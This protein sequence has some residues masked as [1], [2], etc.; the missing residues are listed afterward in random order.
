MKYK[1]ITVETT[2][3]GSDLVSLILIEEGSEGVSVKD[4]KEF[5]SE[6][7]SFSWDYIDEEAFAEEGAF[8]TGVFACDYDES[9]LLSRLDELKAV[10]EFD[11]GSLSVKVLPLMS[12]DYENEWKKYYKVLE[13]GGVA[14]VPE[15]LEYHGSLIPVYIDPG[16]AFGT[17]SHETTSMC[18]KLLQEFDVGGKYVLDVGCG[19]GILGI[20]ALKLGAKR[21]TMSDIDSVCTEATVR[22]CALNGVEKDAEIICGDLTDKANAD[23]LVA[24]ITADILLRL[25][26]KIRSSV[27]SGGIVIIS[28]IIHA[29]AEQVYGEYCKEFTP[30]KRLTDGEWQAMAFRV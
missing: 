19:S 2:T 3:Q 23:V 22:N 1:S 25:K 6:L 15:W 14:I 4:N 30:L 7:K 26:D 11:V 28:G 9:G 27:K 16:K 8:V 13:F 18:I 10:S 17:G 21:C 12:E 5:L 20:T 24:N 29:R